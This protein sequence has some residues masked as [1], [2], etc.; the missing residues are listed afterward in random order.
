MVEI[1]VCFAIAGVILRSLGSKTADVIH[2]LKGTESERMKKWKAR[3]GKNYTPSGFS[4]YWDEAWADAAQRRAEAAADRARRREQY[5]YTPGPAEFLGSWWADAW[6]RA[7][8]RHGDRVAAGRRERGERED[9]QVTDGPGLDLDIPDWVPGAGGNVHDDTKGPIG[10]DTVPDPE[11]GHQRGKSGDKFAQDQADV[12]G[13]IALAATEAN[14]KLVDQL[15][16]NRAVP[17]GA[18]PLAGADIVDADIVESAVVHNDAKSRLQYKTEFTPN[19]RAIQLIAARYFDGDL[20]QAEAWLNE[21]PDAR[22]R[23]VAL[24]DGRWSDGVYTFTSTEIDAAVGLPTTEHNTN[25]GDNMSDTATQ[26]LG[27]T[28]TVGAAL[29]FTQGLTTEL[30]NAASSLEQARADL[31]GSGVTGTLLDTL[32]SAQEAIVAA[33]SAVATAHN[34]AVAH[35]SVGEA[36]RATPGAGEKA[37]VTGE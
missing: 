30:G 29:R 12:L 27:E 31:A 21:H 4:R 34:E 10:T 13:K 15:D 9:E 14:A 3:H 23:I 1:L 11:P 6:A 2:A 25:E 22:K 36:Y 17:G 24:I 33:A 7:I 37:Y 28:G 5:G 18:A 16:G 19:D 20:N 26:P 8:E 32:A 35:T